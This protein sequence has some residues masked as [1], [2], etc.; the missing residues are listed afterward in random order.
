MSNDED[1]LRKKAL[2]STDDIDIDM[3]N[4]PVKTTPL[5]IDDQ[6]LNDEL[7]CIDEQ[8][9]MISSIT[10]DNRESGSAGNG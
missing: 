8:L 1:D 7:R 4:G 3:S 2:D 9:A 10:S 5:N 6:G